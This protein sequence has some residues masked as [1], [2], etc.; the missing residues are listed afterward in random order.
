MNI[1]NIIQ[2]VVLP[3]ILSQKCLFIFCKRKILPF[4]DF[5]MVAY[6]SHRLSDNY[7]D[8]SDVNADLS[9]IHLLDNN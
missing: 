7:L 9:L 2:T 8:L 6:F 3:I 4:D 1:F 5:S